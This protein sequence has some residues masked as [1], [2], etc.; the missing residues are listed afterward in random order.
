MLYFAT[1][2]DRILTALVDN[3]LIAAASWEADPLMWNAIARHAEFDSAH[4]ESPRIALKKL[5]QAH[6]SPAVYR[7]S[8][9]YWRLLY[10]ILAAYATRHNARLPRKPMFEEE[11]LL[12]LGPFR[13]G[14]IDLQ[15]LV[16]TFFWDLQ[17]FPEDAFLDK[18]IPPPVSHR[19]RGGAERYA[20][21]ARGLLPIAHPRWNDN[22]D[23][24]AFVALATGIPRY[25]ASPPPPVVDAR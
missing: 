11:D 13:I 22:F 5:L 7:M 3:A 24:Q 18:V 19:V 12:A 10:D 20:P 17:C 21:E 6:L 4:R 25:P 14:V 8:H 15:H 23:T 16:A 1:K 9:S 2:P